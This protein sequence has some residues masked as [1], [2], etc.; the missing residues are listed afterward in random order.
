MI[1]LCGMNPLHGLLR[2]LSGLRNREIRNSLIQRWAK[3]GQ[4]LRNLNIRN[5]VHGRCEI[6][7]ER[8]PKREFLTSG[9]VVYAEQ[10]SE[11]STEHRVKT[12]I[13][14]FS[15]LRTCKPVGAAVLYLINDA[16]HLRLFPLRLSTGGSSS[17]V[18]RVGS[19]RR[20]QTQSTYDQPGFQHAK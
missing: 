18:R 16:A 14:T 4:L 7:F 11:N 3:S 2:I 15:V 20:C 8:H 19:R 10:V 17:A 12:R 6:G 9:P 13:P 5:K 1:Y